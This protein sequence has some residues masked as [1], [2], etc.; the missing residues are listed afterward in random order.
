MIQLILAISLWKD[1]TTHMCG[2][3]VYVK[4]GLPFAWDLFLENSVD[5]Y[6]LPFTGK[7]WSCCC[8]SF[9]WLSIKFKMGYLF[10]YIA[11]DYFCADCCKRVLEAAKLAFANQTKESITSQ[12]LGS[13]DFWLL[14]TQNYT[15]SDNITK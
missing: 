5:S 3:A 9:H 11:Y 2:L 14:L 12:K 8:L 13:Q 6:F 7:F 1:S 10:H 4:E 15:L